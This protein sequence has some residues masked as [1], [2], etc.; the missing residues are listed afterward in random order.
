MDEHQHLSNWRQAVGAQGMI[1]IAKDIIAGPVIATG[2]EWVD[3]GDG[4]SALALGSGRFL[5]QQ[6]DGTFTSAPHIGP[7]EKARRNGQIVT[8]RSDVASGAIYFSYSWT[9]TP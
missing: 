8:F 9:Q 5:S 6:G 2:V 1:Q 4:C 7:W 3:A